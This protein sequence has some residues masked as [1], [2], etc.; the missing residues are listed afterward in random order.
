M[1]VSVSTATTDLIAKQLMINRPKIYDKTNSPKLY[2]A[3]PNFK[4]LLGNSYTQ[5][6]NNSTTTWTSLNGKPFTQ[7]AKSGPYCKRDLWDDFVSPHFHNAINVETW[8]NGAGGRIG[9]ICG[10]DGMKNAPYDVFEV[11]SV[12]LGRWPSYQD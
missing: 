3:V 10:S 5:N 11:Q 4:L 6:P 7:F 12:Q 8:R 2:S 9:S 1:C